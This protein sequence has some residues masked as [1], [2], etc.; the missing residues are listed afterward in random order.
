MNTA[1]LECFVSLAGT[2]NF[3]RTAEEIGL[4]QPAVSKQIK[5]LEDELGV[6]LFNRTSRS[7][8]LTNA[9]REFLP[10]AN[11][12]L[13]IFYRSR[14]RMISHSKQSEN[15]V[16][17][18]Y[19][20]P[21]VMH[22]ISAVL[23][24]TVS[25]LKKEITP[26]LTLDQTD[27]NLGRLRKEQLDLVIGMR[28]SKFGDDSVSFTKIADNG[29]KFV[30][31]KAHPFAQRFAGTNDSGVITAEEFCD[32]RQII[33]IPQYLL[34]S[35]FSGGK[36]IIPI[37]DACDNVMCTYVSEAYG[38]V[39]CGIGFTFVPEHMSI[40]DPDILSLDW[41][42]SPRAPFGIYHNKADRKN[43]LSHAFIE[44]AKAVYDARGVF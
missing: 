9:G 34:K 21:Q 8:T 24:T 35:V 28:D 12:M 42:E 10:E 19:S 7:V 3:V 4:T 36:T 20:D 5:A 32:V 1:Q 41:K 27:A 43:S 40:D 13:N 23:S 18:G 38:L 29:F 14:Q 2:L 15:V 39:R 16:R 17:I 33:A 37:N 31:S 22:L 11:D 25:E 26:E 6:R 30:I 44:A